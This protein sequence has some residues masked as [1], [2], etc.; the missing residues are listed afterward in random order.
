MGVSPATFDTIATEHLTPVIFIGF[1]LTRYDREQIDKLMVTWQSPPKR[2][3]K[4]DTTA[5]K[6]NK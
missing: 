6:T 2:T 4:N 5:T 3:K 1:D